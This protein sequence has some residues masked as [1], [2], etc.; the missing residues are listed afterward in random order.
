MSETI[1]PAEARSFRDTKPTRLDEFARRLIYS[2]LDRLKHGRLLI[3]EG[4]TRRSFGCVREDYPLEATVIVHH[5]RCFSAIAF[6]GSVGAGE[7]YMAGFWSTDDLT[8][9]VRILTRNQDVLKAVDSRF[10]LLSVPLNKLLHR[11]HQNTMKGS[12]RNIHAHYDLGNDFYSIFLDNTMTYS[13]GIFDRPDDTLE[14]AATR[15]YDRICRGLGLKPTDDVIEIGGGWGGFALHAAS[16]Y[17]SRVTTTTI[18]HEQCDY[19]RAKIDE[20]GLTDRVTVLFQDYRELTG[21]Y[22]KLVSI[23]MLEAVGFERFDRFFHTCASLLKDDGQMCLQTIII[24]DR[25]YEQA[26]RSVDFIKKYIFPGG[27]LPSVAAVCA[28]TSRVTDLQLVRLDDITPHYAVTLR[29][30]RERFTASLDHVRSLGYSDTFIRMWEYYL[31]L[32]EGAF[33]ERH[34]GNVQMFFAKPL[35]KPATVT[36]H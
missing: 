12:L 14:Q 22:D 28:S 7:A 5:T 36:N 35:S 3:I 26:K 33:A 25:Y 15:K 31:S 30:W 4:D 13:C 17:G 16:Q 8:K 23:E 1:V 6:G 11:L 2:A 10:A 19:V 9:V 27:C 32:C 34:I 29:K 24:A 20:H 21:T 18:S